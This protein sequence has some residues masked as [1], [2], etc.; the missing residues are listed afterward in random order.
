V[1]KNK[2]F[3]RVDSVM[4][5]NEICPICER[6]I[7]RISAQGINWFGCECLI[8]QVLRETTGSVGFNRPFAEGRARKAKR[9]KGWSEI[10]IRTEAEEEK[11]LEDLKKVSKRKLIARGKEHPEEWD[12]ILDAMN[13]LNGPAPEPIKEVT[14]RIKFPK[15]GKAS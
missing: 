13:A 8:E 5:L 11:F 9:R 14:R 4:P 3:E 7:C 1:K 10:P 2:Y 6:K 15:N 12:D